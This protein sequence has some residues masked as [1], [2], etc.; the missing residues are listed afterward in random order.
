[1]VGACADPRWAEPGSVVPVDV[2]GEPVLVVR[3]VGGVLR[4]LSA[5]C[6]HRGMLLADAPCRTREIVCGYHGRAFALDGRM[7]RAPGFEDRDDV[8]GPLDHLTRF[9]LQQRG[10][11]LWTRIAT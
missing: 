7:L 10:D 5:V 8:P 11:T 3:D 1:M 4:L 9:P 6:T 2:G